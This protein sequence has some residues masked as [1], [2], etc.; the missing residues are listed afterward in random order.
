[1]PVDVKKTIAIVSYP[2]KQKK[3]VEKGL[4]DLIEAEDSERAKTELS[5]LIIQ[6]VENFALAPIFYN[7]WSGDKKKRVLD[8]FEGS[9][10]LAD[11]EDFS[12]F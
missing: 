7:A 9:K 10:E 4:S 6:R 11:D 5:K 1:M 2:K 8:A 12:L 3:V